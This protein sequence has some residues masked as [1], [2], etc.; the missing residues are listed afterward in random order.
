MNIEIATRLKWIN[1]YKSSG[2]LGITCHRCGISRPTLRKWLRRYEE[3]GIDGLASLSRK[4]HH[5][6]NAKV[7][8]EEEQ[9]ILRL[10]QK[11]NLGTRRIQNELKRQHGISLS[12]ATI[13]KILT[14]NKVKPLRRP[15]REKKILRYSRPIPGD[16]VQMDTCKI[17]PRLYQYTA[18]DDCTRY[19]VMEIYTRRTAANTI[20]F[21]E[22]VIEEMHF[23]IQRI[24]TDRGREFFAYKV[25]EWMKG[26][27]IKFR[28]NKP[29]Q[30]HLNGKVERVQQTD[31]KEFWALTDISQDYGYL[32]DRLS[33]YQHYYNWDRI[34]GSIGKTPMD[35]V[36]ELSQ[37]IPFRDQIEDEYDSSKEYI[38]VQEYAW[39]VKL[40]QLKRSM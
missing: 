34:H 14:Q 11:Y 20:I 12:L 40:L 39:D 31:L 5:S 30:P 22:K 13:H 33:E 32:S 28:P 37:K 23:P 26:Y 38:R 8:S 17:A 3:F 19:Q 15:K 24:Q 9:A 35:K 27:C 18:I 4:P 25:Q 2:N 7:S 29:G 16:R 6:P 1:H 36:V 10:R 21:L